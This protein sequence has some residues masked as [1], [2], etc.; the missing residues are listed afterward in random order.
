MTERTLTTGRPLDGHGNPREGPALTLDPD[1]PAGVLLAQS[2]NALVSDPAGPTWATLLARPDDATPGRPAGA[3][4]DR[5][6]LLQWVAPDAGSPPAHVHPTTET[7]EAVEG[8]VTVVIEGDPVR[9]GRGES[10]TV[11][12]G[13]AHTFRNDTE[14]TVAFTAA[15]PSMR[16][17]R[18]LYTIWGHTHE[19]GQD[20][21]YGRP[22]PLTVLPVAAEMADETTL[23]A[24]PPLL[25]R[26]VLAAVGRVAGA[27][28]D[29][30]IDDR[31]LADDFWAPRVEQPAFADGNSP[32]RVSP[33]P[34]SCERRSQT[35]TSAKSS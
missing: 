5:P 10:V 24:G 18:A 33:E 34:W 8:T 15:L 1:S 32:R 19:G 27:L 7:F 20:G 14:E 2:P 29:G 25:Q 31:Y 26:A 11:A 21:R 13:Q 22:G 35:P 16:T 28:G 17:V 23:T 3:A 12:A 9:L 6:V 4:G 30:G